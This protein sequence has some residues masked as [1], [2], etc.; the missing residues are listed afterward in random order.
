MKNIP[1]IL[2]G[3]V[4]KRLWPMSDTKTPKQFLKFNSEYSLFQNSLFRLNKLK[5]SKPLIVCNEKDKNTIANE[6]KEISFSANVL[7]EPISKNTAPAVTISALKCNPED[8]LIIFPS[9]QLFGNVNKLVSAIKLGIQ[10]CN[11]NN[12]IVFGVKPSYPHIG[13]GYIK[14]QKISSKRIFK[15]TKFVEKPN[16]NKAKKYLLSEKY[17][18]NCGIFIGKSKAFIS[19]LEN[20]NPKI[21]SSCINAIRSGIQ[22]KNYFHINEQAY[23]CCPNI[24]IDYAVMEKTR[25]ISMVN[26]ETS[27]NDLGSWNSVWEISKKDKFNNF[28]PKNIKSI[29]TKNSYFDLKNKN[30]VTI[31]IEDIIVVEKDN[32]LLIINKNYIDEMKN[33]N[34]ILNNK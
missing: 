30:V 17:F 4:G 14:T 10:E 24:S 5:Y 23:S 29:F 2:V 27:W 34:E 32:S 33:I 18:W 26:L 9:D 22:K 19:E 3:G 13:Y 15:V 7:V 25:N 31:G 6:L 20:S 12:F 1:V 21:L 28:S 11:D 8:N 16:I